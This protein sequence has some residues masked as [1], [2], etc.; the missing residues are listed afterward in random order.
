MLETIH[1]IL[2]M[3]TEVFRMINL[4]KESKIQDVLLENIRL[5]DESSKISIKHKVLAEQIFYPLY[6]NIVTANKSALNL[7]TITFTASKVYDS[8]HYEDGLKHLEQSISNFSKRLNDIE[9]KVNMYNNDINGFQDNGIEDAVSDFFRRNGFEV[10]K[11]D[12]DNIPLSTIIL[13]NLLPVLESCWFEKK[14]LLN[15]FLAVKTW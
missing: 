12:I 6:L 7:S 15:L 1:A 8:L 9:R 5:N 3:L 10:S 4:E 2:N 14:M 13:S 11:N